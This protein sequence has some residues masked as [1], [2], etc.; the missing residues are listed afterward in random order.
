[1]SEYEVL[2]YDCESET[3]FDFFSST[4]CFQQKKILQQNWILATEI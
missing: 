4:Q 1:M 2:F 3:L